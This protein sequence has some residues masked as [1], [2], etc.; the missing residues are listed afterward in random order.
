MAAE[1]NFVYPA[2]TLAAL[3]KLQK[4]ESG[5]AKQAAEIYVK[6]AQIAKQKK[7]PLCQDCG[8]AVF[9]AELGR[10]ARIQGNLYK[11]I[12]DG[13][14]QSYTKEYLRKS[15]V[16]DALF[17]R[18][19]TQNNT[20]AIIHLS[21]VEGNNLTLHFLPKGA[22]AENM[23][24][25][26][27]LSPSTGIEE[28]KN[29]VL[30]TIKS[31][32]ANACPPVVVGIGIGGNFESVALMSKHA[33]LREIGSANADRRYNKLEKD[34]LAKINLLNIGPQGFGGKLT[35]FAVFIEHA[36]CHMASLPVAVNIGCHANRHSK[37]VL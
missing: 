26:I 15:V 19:N 27:M 25:L 16:S 21:L 9:F 30:D 6:N 28:V 32:G 29:F 11:A 23:S 12:N 37:V 3:K 10:G 33:L 24:K 20:P 31:V 14:A 22:G 34:L 4:T 18:K 5:L 13:V 1:A 2:R 7:L 17:D 35:A 36:P 8:S